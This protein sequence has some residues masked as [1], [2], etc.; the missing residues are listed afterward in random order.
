MTMFQYMM[1]KVSAIYW[2]NTATNSTFN[3]LWRIV[4]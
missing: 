3:H 4:E 1:E 2:E